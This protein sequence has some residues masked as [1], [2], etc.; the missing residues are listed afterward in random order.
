MSQLYDLYGRDG[1]KVLVNAKIRI[2]FTQNDEETCKLIETMLGNN[3]M[4]ISRI[5]EYESRN[6][7]WKRTI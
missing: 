4:V 2:A 7:R 1:A 5:K 6:D 3:T